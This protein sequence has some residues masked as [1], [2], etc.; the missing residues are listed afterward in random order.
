MAKAKP[1]QSVSA[2][3][4]RQN[5]LDAAR[6]LF[7]AKGYHATT[8]DDITRGAGVAKG[9]FYLYFSEKREI[10]HEVIRGFLQLI[11]KVGG[12]V[13][14][15]A[16]SHVEFFRRAETAAFE[17]MEVVVANRELARLAYRESMGPDPQLSALMRGFYRD[18]AAVEARNIEV[19]IELGIVR[20]VD[21]MLTAYAHIGMVERVL[22]AVADDPSQ[23]PSPAELV[24]QLIRLGFEGFRRADGP[25]PYR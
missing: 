22:L 3:K 25:S 8:V 4:R 14:E 1:T 18:L 9:T 21:P 15:G 7:S 5:L 6:E 17:L 13:A 20:E 24:Q 11:Q 12:S 10:Y 2:S 23:F 19:A 16:Q